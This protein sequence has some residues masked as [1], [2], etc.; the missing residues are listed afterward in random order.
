MLCADCVNGRRLD[1]GGAASA[2]EFF[3]FGGRGKEESMSFARAW[4]GVVLAGLI[5]CVAFSAQANVTR[6][7]V[8][9]RADVLGGKPFGNVGPYEKIVGKAFFAVDP[10]NA[11]NKV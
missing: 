8:A 1:S 5:G 2:V 10:K 6:I 9:S 7:D 4:R 3:Y 11:Q